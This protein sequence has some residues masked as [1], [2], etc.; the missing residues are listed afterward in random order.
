MEFNKDTLIGDL[1][2]AAPDK[3]DILLE[4]G[5]HCFRLSSISNGNFRR[6]L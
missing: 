3:A 5:M 1:L 4:A 2:K 6:S